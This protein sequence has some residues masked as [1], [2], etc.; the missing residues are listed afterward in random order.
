[1][2]SLYSSKYSKISE[3]VDDR[4][5][6][7]LN[8]LAQE[9]QRNATWTLRDVKKCQNLKYAFWPNLCVHIKKTV[10][11]FYFSYGAF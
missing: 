1:M 7:S 2:A 6:N 5:Q 11:S 10:H 8:V 4:H 3:E 9:K